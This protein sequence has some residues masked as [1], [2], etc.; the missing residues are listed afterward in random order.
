MRRTLEQLTGK[1]F[2]KVRPDFLRNPASGRCLELDAF[3]PELQLG[4]EFQGIQ[5]YT[6]PNPF[7]STKERFEAQLHRDKLMV[8]LCAQRGVT[9]LLV[10]DSVERDQIRTFLLDKLLACGWKCLQPPHLRSPGSKTRADL[11]GV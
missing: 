4:C 5:H 7:H 8:E 10:P 6:F 2:V 1:P 3:N 11:P 9:L